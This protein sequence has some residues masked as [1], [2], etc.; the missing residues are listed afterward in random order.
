M[1]WME[2]LYQTYEAGVLLD[3]P[4]E[5]C[6]MPISH[7]MQ[8]AHINI[9]IDG[10]GNF[11]RASVLEKTQVILPATEKSAGRTGKKPPPHP[12]ADKLQ[13]VAKDYPNFGGQKVSFFNEYYNLLKSWCDSKHS[14]PKATAIFEYIKKGVVVKDLSKDGVLVVVNDQLA[15]PNKF[16]DVKNKPAIFKVIPKDTKLDAFDQGAALVCWTVE[17]DGDPVSDT[18]KDNSLQDSWNMFNSDDEGIEGLCFITGIKGA[19]ASNHPSKIRHTGDKAKLISSNDL[20]GFTFLGKFTDSKESIKKFGCQSLGIGLITTQKAHNALSWLIQ[21][22][23]FR[24]GDQAY[25][26][27]AVSGKTIPEPLADAWSFLETDEFNLEEIEGSDTLTPETPL[28][29]GIDLGQ[30]YAQQL[31]KYM[32]GYVAKLSPNEQIIIMGIDSATPGRMGIIYY[33]ELFRDDFL[34]RLE[35]WH[36]EFSWAQRHTI[37][38]DDNTGKKPKTKVIWPISSP[39][40]KDIATAAY[41]DNVND[42]LKKKVIERL[43]PCIIDGQPFPLD[44][45]ISCVRK[46]T[47][48]VGYASDAQW[49]WE[50]NLGIACALYKGYIHRHPN[51]TQRREYAMALE[52]NYHSRDYLYGRLLA[53]AERIEDVGL[54]ISGENRSTTAARLMQRFADRPFETWRT[55]ELALQPY[56]QRLRVSRA[57]FLTNQLKELDAIL[58]LFKHDEF[59][60]KQALS[61][62]FLLAYHC[63]RQKLR[64][65]SETIDETTSQGDTE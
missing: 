15:T 58:A 38:L 53:I 59:S 17:I 8:N 44:L 65:K 60:S 39:V 12:L 61:G 40:P 49:L 57:G 25:V 23:G 34:N 7:T 46:A 32:A 2:K 64:T 31:K 11:K 18:W 35:N 43:I 45:L 10:N 56:M 14:H 51:L 30:S 5:K 13:Y 48:R 26:T 41:G 24:N 52:E 36:K 28:N 37:Q 33:R 27:W 47:N 62:E 4:L 21:R 6:L 19:L 63:Q 1:S 55:I 9:V 20:D 29:H 16:E 54:S 42:S 22:Q 50:K 3:L